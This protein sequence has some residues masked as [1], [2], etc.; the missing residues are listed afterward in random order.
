MDDLGQGHTNQDFLMNAWWEW[1]VINNKVNVSNGYYQL[2]GI[3][4]Q[5]NYDSYKRFVDFIH[6]D[7]QQ[8]VKEAMDNIFITKQ[9]CFLEYRII[10]PDGELRYIQE[11]VMPLLSGENDVIQLKGY[12]I[13][14]TDLK[15]TPAS[16]DLDYHVSLANRRA[17]YGFW[18]CDLERKE[19]FLSEE[20]RRIYNIDSKIFSY[21][22]PNDLF[23]IVE[24]SYLDDV[25]KSFQELCQEKILD[26]EFEIKDNMGKMILVHLQGEVI[27]DNN[28][29]PK[30]VIGTLRN[31]THL[32][33]NEEAV[34]RKEKLSVASQLA[35]GVA[36]EVL[37]PL[38]S[39]HGFLNFFKS[40]A[41]GNPYFD[42]M[43]E[44]LKRVEFI[45]DELLMLAKPVLKEHSY[46][47][48]YELID[49]VYDKLEK[50]ITSKQIKMN[51]RIPQH[52]PK[53]Y[54]VKNQLRLVL[55]NL[56]VNAI[57]SIQEIGVI[58]IIV[59]K[60]TEN[61]IQFIIGDNGCGIPSQLIDLAG[62]PFYTTKEKGTGIGLMVCHRIIENHNGEIKI[63]RKE[64]KG[65][66]VEVV[67]PINF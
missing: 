66:V 56:I 19:V 39:V 12:L 67:L 2:V 47:N 28:H 14:S 32:M 11:K 24:G 9:G 63:R 64:Q 23:Q 60:L 46:V 42:V 40:E 61:K 34:L 30:R 55:I 13:D 8:F 22:H 38:T 29:Q 20:A 58:D 50:E 7:D 26:V 18:E 45:I 6:Q 5:N 43:M 17:D 51:I 57:E 52:L 21:H 1:D 35:A 4:N 15:R 36:H 10:R 27:V 53:L 48:I 31:L 25:K 16:Y 37:N 59:K 3:T 62:Q 49:E 44:D 54:C 41:Y 65:T 33:E